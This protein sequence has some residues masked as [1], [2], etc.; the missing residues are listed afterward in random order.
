MLPDIAIAM[1][2]FGLQGGL[3]NIGRPQSRAKSLSFDVKKAAKK[4]SDRPHVKKPRASFIL[5]QENICLQPP[6]S[7]YRP[8][9]PAIAVI[10]RAGLRPLRTPDLVESYFLP[11][12]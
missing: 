11:P 7:R 5:T 3:E 2:I 6:T 12:L 1:A 10:F 8:L 9:L 4:S